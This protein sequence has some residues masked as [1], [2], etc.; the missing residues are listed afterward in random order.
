MMLVVGDDVWFATGST[1]AE[2]KREIE[3]ERLE[4]GTFQTSFL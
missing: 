2:N 4:M 1:A 3:R